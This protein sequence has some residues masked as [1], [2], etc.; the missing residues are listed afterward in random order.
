M[1][2]PLSF[3]TFCNFYCNLLTPLSN[4]QRTNLHSRNH[5]FLKVQVSSLAYPIPSMTM[6]ASFMPSLAFAAGS[7]HTYVVNTTNPT[8]ASVKA[9]LNDTSKAKYI[10]VVEE[11]THT[12]KGVVK[13]KCT[14]PYCDEEVVV[15]TAPVPHDTVL[16]SKDFT[17]EQYAAQMVVQYKYP[18]NGHIKYDGFAT[19]AGTKTWMEDRWA[20]NHCY[21]KNVGVCSCG[22][23]I[24]PGTWVD[25]ANNDCEDTN[26]PECG[27]AL[28]GRKHVA[29]APTTAEEL[30]ALKKVSDPT[31]GHGTGYEVDCQN[32]DAKTVWYHDEEVD[33]VESDI[34][35]DAHNYGTKVA[36]STALKKLKN[37]T[38]ELKDGYIAVYASNDSYVEDLTGITAAGK[39]GDN[40]CDFYQYNNVKTAPSCATEGKGTLTCTVCGEALKDSSDEDVTVDIPA[41]GHDYEVTEVAATCDNNAYTE[42]VCKVC[43]DTVKTYKPNTKLAHSYKVTSV[44][45]S[46]KGG[47]V[48]TIECTTCEDTCEDSKVVVDSPAGLEVF[49]DTTDVKTV[50][51]KGKAGHDTLS[52]KDA[53]KLSFTK[54]PVAHKYGKKELLKAADCENNEVWGYKCTECGKIATHAT[55]TTNAP[56]VKNNTKLGHDYPVVEVPAT[57][58]S[59]AYKIKGACTRCG[60]SELNAE[61]NKNAAIDAAI[62][63]AKHAGESWA[64]TKIATVF[65]EG[66]KTLVCPACGVEL[67][68][69]TPTAKAKYA[70]PAVKAG[71]KSATV[72]VKATA[73]AEK[74]QISYKKAGGSYKTVSA[75]VGKKTIKKLAKGKKYTFKVIAINAE[76]VKVASA[77]KTVKVK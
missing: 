6:V 68:S 72:T 42:K 22:T 45:A 7:A 66:V 27:V 9:A 53:I 55:S 28:E 60:E 36:A 26:C 65:D 14:Q 40:Q 52:T 2:N 76:G 73:G 1:L 58:V 64:V 29:K 74:Y 11:A 39:I 5:T 44:D 49:E 12:T 35:N 13:V 56:D 59:K 41:T 38:Y 63:G 43:E 10:E 71:K 17:V 67:G 3:Y 24:T 70:A 47:E 75:N 62:Y 57:C 23:I 77:T 31:C 37:G 15:K 33:G 16:A 61:D 51:W 21:K 30:A 8:W 69:K 4:T 46:C 48:Y 20:E 54:K 18:D 34:K 25:H 32:C 19:K 50:L